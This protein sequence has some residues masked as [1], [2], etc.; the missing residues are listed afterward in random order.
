[1]TIS[2]MAHDVA[3]C[4]HCGSKVT[5]LLCA[6]CGT[7]SRVMPSLQEEMD[8]MRELRSLVQGAPRE[9]QMELLTTGFVPAQPDA[10]VEA[11]LL[12]LPLLQ[13]GSADDLSD[14]ASRRLEALLTR[15]RIAPPATNPRAL[16]ELEAR[17]ARYRKADRNLGIVALLVV[18]VLV[19][20][21][22]WGLYAW[23]HH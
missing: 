16:G 20:L 10:L 4:S 1:M 7:P 9:K 2:M 12:V 15:L 13:D 19:G 22:V 8:A 17:L 23:L 14:A 6:F 3:R 5:T 11:A 21:V 18:A